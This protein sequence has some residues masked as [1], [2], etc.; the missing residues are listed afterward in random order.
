MRVD[1]DGDALLVRVHAHGPTCH[2][3]EDTCFFRALAA[4]NDEQGEE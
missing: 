3:G 4:T 2:T 1:C